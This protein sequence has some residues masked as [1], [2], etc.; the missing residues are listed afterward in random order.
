MSR[1][2]RRLRSGEEPGRVRPAGHRRFAS[3]PGAPETRP[4]GG[5]GT[6]KRILPYYSDFF[7]F[8]IDFFPSE[9]LFSGPPPYYRELYNFFNVL[10]VYLSS[11][12]IAIARKST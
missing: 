4:P 8:V 5:P 9:P 1:R 11:F 3:R 7:L 12:I 2:R 6:D 10:L